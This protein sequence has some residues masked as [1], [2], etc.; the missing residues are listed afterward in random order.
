MRFKITKIKGYERSPF[1]FSKKFSQTQYFIGI[2]KIL[3][4]KFSLLNDPFSL[5]M[6]P[7]Q[8]S[9]ILLGY[10]YTLNILSH[11]SNQASTTFCMGSHVA[12]LFI[13]LLFLKLAIIASTAFC[14]RNHVKNSTPFFFSGG[15]RDVHVIP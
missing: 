6:C 14:V 3:R 13:I 11:I 12:L 4:C 8:I 1:F 15:A 10:R 5:K 9:K 2:F 7:F